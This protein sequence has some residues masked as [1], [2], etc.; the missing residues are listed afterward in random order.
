MLEQA[1]GVHLAFEQARQF[2]ADTNGAER[3]A[4]D[5]E[6]VLARPDGVQLQHVFPHRL[7]GAFERIGDD[8]PCPPA[9]RKRAGSGSDAWA[10][11]PFGVTG[12]RVSTTTNAGTACG[13]ILVAS[14]C[15]SRADKP[16]TRCESNGSFAAAARAGT[17]TARR[18]TAATGAPCRRSQTSNRPSPPPGMTC[19]V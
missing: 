5:R 15:R 16:L 11:L 14:D 18:G 8:L 7:D 17:V 12:K 19:V 1:G 2:R 10:I 9:A 3:I 4:T 13:G 6:E